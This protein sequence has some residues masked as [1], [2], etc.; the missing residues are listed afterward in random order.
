M[1]LGSE[2]RNHFLSFHSHYLSLPSYFVYFWQD[3]CFKAKPTFFFCSLPFDL[4]GDY[5]F[6]GW[7]MSTLLKDNLKEIMKN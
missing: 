3:E 1:Y 6:V 5:Y 2:Q 7:N 4:Y